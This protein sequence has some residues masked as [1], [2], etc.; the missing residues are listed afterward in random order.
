MRPLI[1]IDKY[2]TA[3]LIDPGPFEDY[4]VNIGKAFSDPDTIIIL[5]VTQGQAYG[6]ENIKNGVIEWTRIKS[7]D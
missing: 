4:I 7:E 2:G 1:K 3:S 6:L 5:K